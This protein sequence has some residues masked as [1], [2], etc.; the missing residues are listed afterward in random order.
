MNR[1]NFLAQIA[2]GVAVAT[3]PDI[4]SAQ[5]QICQPFFHPQFGWSEMCEIG[6][7]ITQT[8]RQ[9]CQVWCWAACCEAI[10]GLAGL[11]IDQKVFVQKVF[12]GNMVC[13]AADGP[14]IKHAIDGKWTAQ[15]GQSVFA[16]ANVVMDSQF[17]VYDPQP[18]RTV[19]QELSAGRAL[20]TGTLNH[21]VLITA[22]KYIQTQTGIE[23]LEIIVR[24]PWPM[25]P[26]RRVMTPQEYHNVS[27]LMTLRLS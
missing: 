24:D 25:N 19:Y 11:N 12:G 5:T 21:A 18:L 22:M 9:E 8:P 10:F 4:S 13:Q 26:N 20:L 6:S 7:K 2:S 14:M 23:P 16:T 27:L 1:R 17:G 3:I 15:N